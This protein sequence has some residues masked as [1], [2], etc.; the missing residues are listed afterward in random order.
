MKHSVSESVKQA[1]TKCPA[2][3]SCLTTG[4]CGDR[5]MCAVEYANGCPVLFLEDRKGSTCPYRLSFGNRQA[6]LCPT[7]YALH[8]AKR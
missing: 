6:C 5:E 1:T 3:L 2:D 8:Q 4:K 7:H